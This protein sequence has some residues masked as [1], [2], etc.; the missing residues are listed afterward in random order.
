MSEVADAIEALLASEGW[1]L[2]SEHVKAEWSPAA[3]WRK[4]KAAEGDLEK[5]DY[6][7]GQVG[8]LMNWP[9]QEIARLR[10]EEKE[11]EPSMSR[12]GYSR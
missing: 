3:C 9:T 12:G 6:T 7:N 2:Y 4:V 8:L 1:R 5:V 11:Q 10:R